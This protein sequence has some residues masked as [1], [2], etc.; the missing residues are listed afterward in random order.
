MKTVNHFLVALAL[1]V[2]TLFSANVSIAQEKAASLD[3]L[4]KLVSQA[5]LKESKEAKQREAEFK[6]KKSQ[7]AR[8]LAQLKRTLKNAENRSERLKR[9]INDNE[10]KLAEKEKQLTEKLGSLQELFGHLTSAAGDL[11]EDLDSSIISAQ[12]PGRSDF[13]ANMIEQ[14]TDP[15]ELPSIDDIRRVWENMM[16]QMVESSKV[17]KFSG[18][19]VAPDGSISDK[20]IV[21]IGNYNLMADGKYLSYNLDTKRIKELVKQPSGLAQV[22]ALESAS[23]GFTQVGI[24]PTGPRGGTFLSAIVLTPDQIEQWHQG[25]EVGYVITVLGALAV[26][27]A[28]WRLIYLS[29]VSGRVR[30]QLKS[31]TA[32]T[33]NPLGR[34]LKVYEDDKNVDVETLEL[35]LNE[36][37]IKERP[38]IEAWLNAIKIIAAISPLLGLL[39]TVTGMILTFQGIMI[40]GAGDV[41]GMANGISQALQTTKLG[42][43]AAVPAVLMHTV[44][45]SRATRIIHI[46]DEQ[47]AGIVAEKAGG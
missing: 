4:L 43:F 42:L 36:A 20:E 44:V 9:N 16:L 11:R 27:L 24:D 15:S 40:Y 34:I 14:I 3:E 5:K 38:S 13:I 18:S 22:S 12:Y 32:N 47:A 10:L 35:R 29:I 26:V 28:I 37:I 45:N 39:G 41:A 21:R 7:Q 8:A 19:V 31:E 25:G 23:S 46:M 33:N 30:A 1:V 17:T 6:Q 2:T